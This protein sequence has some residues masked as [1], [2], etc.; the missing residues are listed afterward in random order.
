M[1]S[2]GEK[3]EV[4]RSAGQVEE[5][6]PVLRGPGG[7]GIVRIVIER[8]AAHQA[9]GHEASEGKHRRGEVDRVRQ[10]TPLDDLLAGGLHHAPMDGYM[11]FYTRAGVRTRSVVF[12]VRKDAYN[13]CRF[14]LKKCE[15][16]RVEGSIAAGDKNECVM[17]IYVPPEESRAWEGSRVAGLDALKRYLIGG[18]W[19]WRGMLS[20]MQGVATS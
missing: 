18:G 15:R 14:S 20:M 19:S 5:R 9:A 11:C 3:E 17:S 2:N 13:E 7:V 12:A 4:R 6:P 8:K 10:Q 16:H 1:A